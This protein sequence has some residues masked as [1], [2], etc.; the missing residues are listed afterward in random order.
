M[1]GDEGLAPFQHVVAQVAVDRDP[2][3]AVAAGDA[4]ASGVLDRVDLAV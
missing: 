4:P 2:H 1:R 3:A